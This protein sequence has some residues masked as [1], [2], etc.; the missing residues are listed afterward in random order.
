VL[1][2]TA[3]T[4]RQRNR[5]R[6]SPWVGALN[7]GFP[8]SAPI[9]DRGSRMIY[10]IARVVFDTT[11]GVSLRDFTQ[12][13]LVGLW[14]FTIQS[15][16]T[17]QLEIVRILT[18]D[19]IWQSK[20]VSPTDRSSKSHFL[21]EDIYQHIS[22]LQRAGAPMRVGLLRMY[23]RCWFSQRR[24]FSETKV[25]DAGLTL[26]IATEVQDASGK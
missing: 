17:G 16:I 10:V 8:P 11:K 19:Y 2:R 18:P 5:Q 21:A 23:V 20:L 1:Y 15:R 4:N 6:S 25:R 12:T 22:R 24:W 3:A 9:S 7:L 14:A 26:K 13:R